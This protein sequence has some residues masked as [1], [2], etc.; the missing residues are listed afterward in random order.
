[1]SEHNSKVQQHRGEIH[2]AINNIKS[3]NE[4]LKDCDDVSDEKNCRTIAIDPEKYLKSKPPPSLKAGTKLPITL[5]YKTSLLCGGL[6][7]KILSKIFVTM[8]P[9]ARIV[10]FSFHRIYKDIKVALRELLNH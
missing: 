5:R 6:L 7:S 8:L 10:N 1:M 2:L 4:M 9:R 3:V